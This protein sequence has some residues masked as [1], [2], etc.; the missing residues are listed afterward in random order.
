M[1]ATKDTEYVYALAGKKTLE[2]IGRIRAK[3]AQAKKDLA[4]IARDHGLKV[5]FRAHAV[6]ETR[7]GTPP[8]GWIPS[9]FVGEALPAGDMY[10][11]VMRLDRIL[12][13]SVSDRFNSVCREARSRSRFANPMTCLTG[14]Y[15][16]ETF[17][18]KT[19][20]KCP[21]IIAN[22]AKRT[23]MFF[24]PRDCTPISHAAYGRLKD[25]ARKARPGGAMKTF[26]L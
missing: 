7:G 12:E 11:R 25:K 19:V 1:D 20:I 16:V 15:G 8:R 22:D 14:D 9:A 21:K 23:E 10:D 26:S 4:R 2:V 13:E 24:V 3:K 18:K 5:S 17:G 6:F